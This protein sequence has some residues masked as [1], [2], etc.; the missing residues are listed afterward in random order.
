MVK[1]YLRWEHA[2]TFGVIC[3][4]TSNAVW[5]AD[6]TTALSSSRSTG[7]GLAVVPA[8]EEVLT[9]DIKKGTLNSR[10]RDPKCNAEVSVISQS[11]TDP[12]IFAV[13]YTDGSIR[14][15][16]SKTGT[17][18]IS[19]NGHKTAVTVLALD[20]SGTRLASGSRDAHIIVWDLISEVGLY[21]LK[22][23]KDQITGL[24][25][26][27]APE[28][29]GEDAMRD[30][31]DGDGWLL[32]TGKDTLI[33]LW[34]LS[35]QHCVETHIAHHGECWSMDLM[36]DLNGCITGGNDGEMK[37]WSI[38]W[39]KLQNRTSGDLD[40][41]SEQGTL[42]RKIR[43]RTQSVRFHPQGN[44][45]AVHGTDKNVEI[46][47][48]RTGEEVQKVMKRKRKR[49]ESKGELEE[50]A[51]LR[52]EIGDII[53]SHVTVRAGGKVRSLDWAVTGKSKSSNF[54][55]LISSTNNSLEYY[56]VEKFSEKK[57]AD[58]A[59]QPDYN[60]LHSVELSGHRTDIRALSLSSDDRMLASASNGSLKVWN[61]RTG[62]CIRTFECG[63]AL[64]CSFLPGDK[65]IVVG[66]NTG[67]LELYDV[68]SSS[69][70]DTVKAHEGKVWSLQVQPDGKGLVSGSADKSAIF[71]NFE[72][73]QE[74]I[75]GTKRT[76]PKLQLV[77]SRVLKVSDDILSVRLS[78][79]NKL[80][81]LALLDNTVKVFF[82]D[83]LKHLLTLYGHKL[84]VLNMD[85]SSDSKLIATCSADKNVKIWGLDF[86]DCHKS[87]FAHQDSIMQVAF[88]KNSHYFF[89]ASKDK[90]IKY[91][92]GDKFEQIMK[93]EGHHGEV[94]AMVVGSV[95]NIVMSASHD[96]SIRM[97]EQ[98]DEPIFLEEEREKELEELYESTLATSLDKDSDE[99]ANSGEVSSAGKQTTET[100]MAG[101][102]IMEALELGIEDLALMKEYRI[103]KE[104]QP[105]LAPPPRNALYA[106]LG[107]VSAEK[108]V[109]DTV[110]RIKAASLEDALLVLPFDKVVALMT[111]IDIWAKNEWNIPL[112]SRILFFILK[113]HHKQIIASRTM[114]Q[115]LD[116]VR[117]HLR[118]ALEHQK[119]EMGFNLAALRFVKMGV[120]ERKTRNFVDEEEYKEM[121]ERGRK[122]RAFATVA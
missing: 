15:W 81:A 68:A 48:I 5:C 23:H 102:R 25:F 44:Y 111:F 34:D 108:H 69:I 67:E 98:T 99:A 26:L 8:N 66:T 62:A 105:N 103:A 31:A 85:I 14:L 84:P 40:C 74:E 22:G 16:D 96:K 122:K 87:F 83:S 77:R 46:W 3:S 89:S 47:R 76:I 53:V 57:K 115:M 20:Q 79:D 37:V 28:Q 29:E 13:G 64:C 4:A 10:W 61:V 38:D 50:D 78:P 73:V 120:E 82:T 2:Q 54:H 117:N 24:Q 90:V 11:K 95:S 36:P 80:L 112:T 92:D 35:T 33:K 32:S 110:Q 106:A 75:P 30:A 19:F 93:M 65:I 1:S 60:K 21:R 88:E 114:R 51:E 107:G 101:E 113:T 55:L 43:D 49:K 59:E 116:D 27:R 9:W 52:P 86:G 63:Y 42:Y 100:L 94:L 7:A 119:D 18:I 72:I 12:D 39:E 91:W 45:F 58:K 97:W 70:M 71:W 6:P 118:A 104:S 121:A 41:I 56:E 17:V 109:L